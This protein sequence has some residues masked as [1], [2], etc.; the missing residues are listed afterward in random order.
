MLKQ[1]IAEAIACLFEQPFPDSDSCF[2]DGRSKS[3]TTAS[4]LES[5]RFESD[6]LPY[7]FYSDRTQSLFFR[8][9][10][11]GFITHAFGNFDIGTGGSPDFAV[12]FVCNI[13]IFFQ[14][15]T[16]IIFALTD[17]RTVVAVPCA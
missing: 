6:R 12:D 2:S 5:G 14:P 8:F 4:I 13:G 7:Q 15:N 10:S 3:K 9:F 1:A 11:V 17:F 16:N